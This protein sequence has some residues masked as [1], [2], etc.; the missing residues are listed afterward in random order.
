MSS[1]EQ[2]RRA[3]PANHVENTFA[4][5]AFL[6]EY[7]IE[8]DLGCLTVI[9]LDSEC[10]RDTVAVEPVASQFE[11]LVRALEEPT[12]RMLAI[13]TTADGDSNYAATAKQL[14]AKFVGDGGKI[15]TANLSPTPGDATPEERLSAVDPTFVAQ[16]EEKNACCV[17]QIM[18]GERVASTGKTTVKDGVATFDGIFTEMEFQRR[19]LA[20]CVMAF[21]VRWALANGAA[22]GLLNGSPHGQMLYHSLGW[23]AIYDVINIGGE[24]VLGFLDRMRQKY[25]PKK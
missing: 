13:I 7:S 18:A 10:L 2:L 6:R 25:A 1:T 14:G 21:L 9:R 16:I 15:M 17:V 23:T 8:E 24:P 22:H 12:L 19:G 11:A 4:S 5:W 20:T 3:L